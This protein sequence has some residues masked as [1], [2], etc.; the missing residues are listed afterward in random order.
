MPQTGPPVTSEVFAVLALAAISIIVVLILRHY[1]PLR[2]TPAYLLVPVFFALALPASMVLLVPIDLASATKSPETSAIILPHRA[3]LVAWR[4]AYWLTFALTWFI[5]PVLGEY[6]DSGYREPRE[7]LEDSLRANAQYYAIMFG[8]GIVGLFYVFLSYGH[9]STSLKS[10]VMALAYCWGLALAIYLMGHGLVA[11]PKRLVRW[12]DVRG[13]L[14]RIYARAPKVYDKLKDAEMALEELEAQVAELSRRKGGS[15]SLFQDW[16]EELVDLTNLPESQPGRVAPV[17]PVSAS[18]SALPNVITAKFLA[19]LTQRLLH[20]RHSRTRYAAE[21]SRLLRSAVR[22]QAIVESAAS[23][24]L[25]FTNDPSTLWSR[26]SPLTPYTRHLLHF[27]LLPFLSLALGAVL[28]LASFV[29][30]SSELLKPFFPHAAPIR[31]TVLSSGNKIALFPGQA[32]SSLCL[33]Y[34]SLATLYSLTELP[35]TIWRGRAL[36]RR[37]T[38]H[39]S[40]FWYASQIARLGVP[41]T[42]NFATLLGD[43]VYHRTVFYN[44]L[45]SGI[46]LTPLS[47]WFDWL[48]PVFILFPVGMALG[49]VYGRVRRVWGAWLYA[50]D[51]EELNGGEGDWLGGRALIEREVQG[52]RRADLFNNAY[53]DRSPLTPSSPIPGRSATSSPRPTTP[54]ATSPNQSSYLSVSRVGSS[55]PQANTSARRTLTLGTFSRDRGRIDDPEDDDDPEREGLLSEWTHRVKNTIDTLEPPR[56][57]SEL[58]QGFRRPRWLAG[59][60]TLP[61]NRS[62]SSGEGPGDSF[63]RWFGGSSGGNTRF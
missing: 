36:V 19:S 63:R 11:I 2:T 28:A 20:A 16:I 52:T 30:V 53:R 25:V 49:G 4:I 33:S 37:N 56:W 8:L 43:E 24:R 23:K 39:E 54:F 6:S 57:L 31:L 62:R 35:L 47:S 32:I 29:I 14:R 51:D 9:F 18:S 48:F 15:A 46:N 61:T 12:A 3:I 38:S 40:A 5:L 7:K 60:E 17:A 50:D 55:R 34:M 58:G 44:F 26:I 45:G 27:Y 1:L 41:L 10:T 13:R 21:W 42:Y 22:T 59:G